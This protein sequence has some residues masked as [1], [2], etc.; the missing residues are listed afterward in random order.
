MEVRVLPI[1]TE[2]A[3][4]AMLHEA[5]AA[6]LD[7][8][9]WTLFWRKIGFVFML[10]VLIAWSAF[11]GAADLLV[12]P[13]IFLFS[14][15][16]SIC[17][18]CQPKGADVAAFILDGPKPGCCNPNPMAIFDTTHAFWKQAKLRDVRWPTP[19]LFAPLH[20]HTLP[21]ATFNSTAKHERHTT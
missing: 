16:F 7:A 3:G 9:K 10:L 18:C 13:I 19:Y 1:S 8:A 2:D 15:I 14:W 20:T 5:L 11:V 21:C 12:V 6:K 4:L 17:R